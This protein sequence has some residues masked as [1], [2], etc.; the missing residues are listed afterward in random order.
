MKY[1]IAILIFV[2]VAS[3][4]QKADTTKLQ[5][6]TIT[7]R[8]LQ[9]EAL[10]GYEKSIQNFQSKEWIAEQL[11]QLTTRHNELLI[12]IIDASGKDI[13]KT[14]IIG[15]DNGKMIVEESE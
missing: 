1:I 8:P 10:L 13:K 4:A 3:F 2:S 9:L 6:D 5:K 15:F 11:Q 7:L 12:F 14:K